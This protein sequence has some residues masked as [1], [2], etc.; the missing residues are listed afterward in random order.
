LRQEVG[1]AFMRLSKQLPDSLSGLPAH[2]RGWLEDSRDGV[3]A[4]SGL[5]T[6]ATGINISLAKAGKESLSIIH[7]GLKAPAHNESTSG[8]AV[9]PESLQRVYV[10]K[11]NTKEWA[12]PRAA[13][14]DLHVCLHSGLPE[15]SGGIV[16][17]WRSRVTRDT[18]PIVGSSQLGGPVQESLFERIRARERASRSFPIRRSLRTTLG[19]DGGGPSE[20]TSTSPALDTAP[21][22]PRVDTIVP[23][24]ALVRRYKRRVVRVEHRVFPA[25]PDAV[26]LDESRITD[27][28]QTNTS[29]AG[30]VSVRRRICTEPRLVLVRNWPSLGGLGA[31]RAPSSWP[32][33]ALLGERNRFGLDAVD[34]L[35]VLVDGIN[36]IMPTLMQAASPLAVAMFERFIPSSRAARVLGNGT[37]AVVGV[38]V[39]APACAQ[40]KIGAALLHAFSAA[41]PFGEA[42]AW[43]SDEFIVGSAEK[44]LITHSPEPLPGLLP[45]LLTWRS[46]AQGSE[47]ARRP[48]RG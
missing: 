33:S 17:S 11:Y 6:T 37:V 44:W 10:P 46:V 34:E 8:F 26:W 32:A 41:L 15:P 18:D 14:P 31:G 35:P 16:Q 39:I 23:A 20:R 9:I 4:G 28:I 29:L 36:L 38:L 12:I 30:E 48:R 47:E 45:V 5:G 24:P 1:V 3:L 2:R 19:I 7:V 22:R 27:S 43:P 21:V 25:G 13:G 40:L 42:G